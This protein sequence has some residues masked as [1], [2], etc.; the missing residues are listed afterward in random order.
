MIDAHPGGSVEIEGYVE[1]LAAGA[2]AVGEYQCSACGYGAV[3]RRELPRCPM[4]GGEVWEPVPWS[5]FTR[6]RQSAD[7]EN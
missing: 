1:F 2:K 7:E 3:V 5:P 4:C 6:A